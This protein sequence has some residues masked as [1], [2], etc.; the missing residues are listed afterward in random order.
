M[1]VIGLSPDLERLLTQAVQAVGGVGLEPGLADT[2]GRE[3]ARLADAQE[4]LGLPP[5]LLV[6]APLRPALSRMLRRMVPKLKVI[7]HSEVPD[8]KRIKVTAAL[9]GK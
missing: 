8:A 4:Q 1:Q 9:G 6:P 7:A 5:V 2:L 3:A